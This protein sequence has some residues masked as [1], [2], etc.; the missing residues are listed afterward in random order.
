M[1]KIRHPAFVNSKTFEENQS[2]IVFSPL[3][4]HH[5]FC[6]YL[7]KRAVKKKKGD[8]IPLSLDS[9]EGMNED[10]NH[11]ITN[12][13]QNNSKPQATPIAKKYTKHNSNNKSE[14][15][16]RHQTKEDNRK[17][18]VNKI[19]VSMPEKERVKGFN[20]LINDANMR[21]EAYDQIDSAC[22]LQNTN[23]KK[24]SIE[25]W[26]AI[27]NERFIKYKQ[28]SELKLQSKINQKIIESKEQEDK[29]VE[30]INKHSKKIPKEEIEKIV[31]RLHSHSKPKAKRK[32]ID[33]DDDGDDDDIWYMTQMKEVIPK[34]KAGV[35]KKSNNKQIIRNILIRNK[36]KG[37][38]LNELNITKDLL[39]TTDTFSFVYMRKPKYAK[40]NNTNMGN[41]QNRNVAINQMN[42][43]SH[44][45]VFN[46]ENSVNKIIDYLLMKQH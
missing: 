5:L 31:N 19:K 16:I 13:Q 45:N 38:G 14:Q 46:T 32:K 28:K 29:A 17:K 36:N 6:D 43:N 34:P 41:T 22:L 37:E 35:K 27:Y 4:T 21:I 3:A 26:N 33:G 18:K 1:K 44:Y 25:K 39:R 23:I 40:E 20:S 12:P 11:P 7:I 15:F 8:E 30:R 24:V 42:T 9:S 10:L 2:H